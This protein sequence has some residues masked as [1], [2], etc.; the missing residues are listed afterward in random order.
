MDKDVKLFDTFVIFIN[1]INFKQQNIYDLL[2]KSDNIQVQ[3]YPQN[4]YS[5]ILKFSWIFLAYTIKVISIQYS[6]D[7][8]PLFEFVE[9]RLL[10]FKLGLGWKRK[11]IFVFVFCF[12]KTVEMGGEILPK[13]ADLIR[14][15]ISHWRATVGP[16][17][18][19]Q[20]IEE[21]DLKF[22]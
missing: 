20:G 11:V 13:V 21:G 15:R 1:N 18:P 2:V 9:V 4:I 5:N 10:Q 19:A 14:T 17:A 8:H 16:N 22:G 3:K 7:L 6:L 12:L